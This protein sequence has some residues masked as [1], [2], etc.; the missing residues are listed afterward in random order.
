MGIWQGVAMEG[1][2]CPTPLRLAGGHSCNGHLQGGRPVGVLWPFGYPTLQASGDFVLLSTVHRDSK[3][4]NFGMDS[5][6]RND[7]LWVAIP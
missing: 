6:G 7:N 4:V 3:F 5:K 1:P 2:P